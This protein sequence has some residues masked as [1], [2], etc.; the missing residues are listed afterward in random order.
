MSVEKRDKSKPIQS[1]LL[2]RRGSYA[3]RPRSTRGP[4]PLLAD[5]RACSS[6]SPRAMRRFARAN[7]RFHCRQRMTRKRR[8]IHSSSLS[9]T[10]RTLALPFR[11]RCR[12]HSILMHPMECRRQHAAQ[13]CFATSCN[14][15]C[16]SPKMAR[17]I[18]LPSS[19]TPGHCASASADDPPKRKACRQLIEPIIALAAGCQVL[20]NSIECA[21][22]LNLSP[23][24]S[25]LNTPIGWPFGSKADGT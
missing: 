16:H 14:L 17:I 12:E 21:R 20:R 19:V 6:G 7:G 9:K 2:G 18:Y 13:T 10:L 15:D 3:R 24:K 8:L 4:W 22:N 11:K 23:R 25:A 5:F 1:K